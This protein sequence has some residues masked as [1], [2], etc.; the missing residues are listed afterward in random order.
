MF[1]MHHVTST[2]ASLS[3]VFTNTSGAVVLWMEGTRLIEAERRGQLTLQSNLGTPS[4]TSSID[5]KH[6]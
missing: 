4:S 2:V 3:T 6:D 5:Y 1:L